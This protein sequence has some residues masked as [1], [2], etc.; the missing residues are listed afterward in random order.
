VLIL[1]LLISVLFVHLTEQSL[2]L[3]V[4]IREALLLSFKLGDAELWVERSS[5]SVEANVR[6]YK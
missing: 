2:C 1:S 5:Y 4:L 3:L 6:L